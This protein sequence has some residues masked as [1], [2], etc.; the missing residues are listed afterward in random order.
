MLKSMTAYGRASLGV[1]EGRFVAEIQSLNRKFQDILVLLPRELASLETEIRRWVGSRVPRGRITLRIT[2][3]YE[4]QTPFRVTPNLPLAKQI[5]EA[6]ETVSREVNPEM[7]E[8]V[9]L[10][11]LSKEAGVLV[12]EDNFDQKTYKNILR[13]VVHQ[14]VD[15]LS[16]M[17]RAEGTSISEEFTKRIQTIREHHGQIAQQSPHFVQKYQEKLKQRLETL[18]T[19][20]VENEERVLRE[21]A[22]YAERVD[23]SEELSRLGSHLQ[24][25]VEFMGAEQGEKGKTL[26]FLLQEMQREANTIASKSED[27]AIIKSVISIKTEIEKMKE[28]VQNVV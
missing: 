20:A 26:E 19:G 8:T 27:V 11:M 17:Q 10:Q 1:K 15:A 4:I 9:T 22:L 6:W 2:A 18:L 24:Q 14:A 12:Y 21:I 28:Q 5:K 7:P 3:S 16:E 23:V 25:F 13:Q